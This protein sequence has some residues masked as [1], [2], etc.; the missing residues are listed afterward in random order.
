MTGWSLR[1]G[2]RS[3]LLV[4]LA[5]SPPVWAEQGP[6]SFEFYGKLYPEWKV[7]EF[8]DPARAGATVG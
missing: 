3:S 2:R 7:Q 5:C 1:V 8:G 4:M 6:A